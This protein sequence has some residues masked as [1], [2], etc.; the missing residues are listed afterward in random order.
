MKASESLQN[1]EVAP[2]TLRAPIERSW[3]RC[4][5]AGIDPARVQAP[6]VLPDEELMT[7]LT[8][9]PIESS[10]GTS[11]WNIDRAGTD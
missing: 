5:A 2:N 1:G 6:T 4:L 11:Q 7:L 8:R 9:V 3:S 10:G